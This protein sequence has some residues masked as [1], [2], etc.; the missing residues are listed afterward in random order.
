MPRR[1]ASDAMS[2]ET[3]S[4]TIGLLERRAARLRR[5]IVS[6]AAAQFAHLGGAMSCADLMA[7]LFFHALRLDGDARPRDHFLLSKGHAVHAL[8]ACLVELGQLD[9]G[10]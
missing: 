3:D 4:A 7:A 1:D 5:H 6:V 2:D 9:A 8:H 10:E